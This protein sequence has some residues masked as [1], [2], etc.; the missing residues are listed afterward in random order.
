M[1]GAWG[2]GGGVIYRYRHA[3]GGWEMIPGALV[4]VDG[5]NAGRAIGKF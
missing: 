3:I 1:D 5:Y 2:L 4:Q